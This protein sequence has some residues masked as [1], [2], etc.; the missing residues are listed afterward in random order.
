M[1]RGKCGGDDEIVAEKE[2][3]GSVIRVGFE[4][5]RELWRR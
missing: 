4:W 3:A 5:V 1:D 2:L